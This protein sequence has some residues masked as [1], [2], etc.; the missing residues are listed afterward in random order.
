MTAHAASPAVKM[1][2]IGWKDSLQSPDPPEERAYTLPPVKSRARSLS[3]LA[4]PILNLGSDRLHP[5]RVTGKPEVIHV[6]YKP[7]TEI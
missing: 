1:L 3:I 4:S 2:N 5:V 6:P 7:I